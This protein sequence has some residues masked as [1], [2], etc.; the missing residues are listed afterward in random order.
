MCIAVYISEYR[1]AIPF[2]K[3]IQTNIIKTLEIINLYFNAL[4]QIQSDSGS[5]FKGK[6]MQESAQEHNMK[7]IFYVLYYPKATGLVER[8]NV[9]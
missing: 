3:T 8:M 7:W 9:C 6:L 2:G 4:L 1:V 5:G